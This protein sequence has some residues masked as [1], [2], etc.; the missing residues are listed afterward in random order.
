MKRHYE[1]GTSSTNGHSQK[2]DS[3]DLQPIEDLD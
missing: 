3:Q 1:S 2:V